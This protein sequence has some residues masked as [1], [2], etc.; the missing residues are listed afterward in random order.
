MF[1][2]FEKYFVASLFLLVLFFS[3]GNVFASTEIGTISSGSYAWGEKIGWINFGCSNCS[4]SVKDNK[5]TGYAW[6]AQYGWINLSPSQGGVINNGE[7]VLS[8]N[9][10]SENVGWIK[11]DGV[12]IN[13]SGKFTGLAGEAS[14]MS[15][16]I[17]FDCNNCSVNTDWRPVSVRGGGATTTPATSTKPRHSGGTLLTQPVNT[18]SGS[19]STTMNNYYPISNESIYN[20][21][22]QSGNN[23]NKINGFNSYATSTVLSSSSLNQKSE[24]T[25]NT[26]VNGDGYGNLMIMVWL[27]VLIILG[28]LFF[29]FFT[30]FRA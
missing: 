19:A 30:R 11:F 23:K 6:S 18:Q 15:G 10:W 1:N 27:F 14:A 9:A 12:T 2:I 21:V 28:M 13:N 3:A 26:Q 17:N 29:T 7:G 8:G 22:K 24:V 20:Q 16:R 4:V 5:L 25:K